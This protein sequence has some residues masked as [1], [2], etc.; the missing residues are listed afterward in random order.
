M[1]NNSKMQ[2]PNINMQQPFG[3]QPPNSLTSLPTATP[4]PSAGK[5]DIGMGLQQPVNQQM[6]K[7]QLHPQQHHPGK[8]TT[9]AQ[10]SKQANPILA[11]QM[12][13]N[14]MPSGMRAMGGPAS[15][16]PPNGANSLIGLDKSANN[17]PLMPSLLSDKSMGLMPFDEVEQS[18]ASMEQPNIAKC[19]I[20]SMNHMDLLS[21]MS[22]II[23]KSSQSQSL[24]QQLGFDN[25]HHGQ[26]DGSNNGFLDPALGLGNGM[27]GVPVTGSSGMMMGG[28]SMSHHNSQ[29]SNP[30]PSMFDPISTPVSRSL[31]NMGSSNSMPPTSVGGGNGV[32]NTSVGPSP[33]GFRPKPIE[34]L[35]QSHDKKTPPPMDSKS[36][37]MANAF[38]KGM[39]HNMKNAIASSWSS[40]AAA[41]SPQN[42]PTSNKPK[43]P[44]MDSFQQFRNK[45]KEKADREKQELRRSHK[46]AA[47]KRQQQEQQQKL[48]RDE[49]DTAR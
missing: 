19:D 39:E 23:A 27:G 13:M 22:H 1:Q 18:L 7:Q 31:S 14:M 37:Q 46:E 38:H 47:E 44:A 29:S 6:L 8:P 26:H 24:M 41:G 15:V 11:Q 16:V 34:E 36:G 3:S 2:T 10:N 5:F 32:G 20:D 4:P 21:D 9:M 43:Q 28:M 17:L 30:M 40:L 45:A 49:V 42:T 25:M 12:N 35:L 48:K 33:G